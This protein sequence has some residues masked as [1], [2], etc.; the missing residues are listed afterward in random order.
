[1]NHQI[2][3]T[4]PRWDMEATREIKV[5]RTAMGDRFVMTAPSRMQR[6]QQI[7]AELCLRADAESFTAKQKADLKFARQLILTSKQFNNDKEEESGSDR[8]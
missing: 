1:M 5:N 3:V 8:S 6:I 4:I 7:Y 2:I